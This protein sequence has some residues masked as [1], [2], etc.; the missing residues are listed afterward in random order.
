MNDASNVSTGKPK[1]TGSIFSAPLGT[2]LP[3]DAVS[4][5]AA[6]FVHHG[7]G[8]EDGVTNSNSPETEKIKAWGGD[9]VLVVQNGREDT[10]KVKLIEAMNLENL[11]V[12]YGQDNVTG[13]M[14]EGIAVS[15]NS[16][17]RENRSWVIDMV[18]KNAIKRIV[19]PDAGISELGEIKYADKEAIGYEIT[20]SAV[21]DANGNT[22]YEYIKKSGVADARLTG[23][24]IGSLELSPSFSASVTEYETETSNNSDAITATAASGATIVVLVNGSSITNGTAPTWRT[25]SNLV[26][27]TVD[28]TGKSA[29]K[30]VITVTKEE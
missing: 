3:T 25:G 14:E 10:F 12:V 6:A 22:H 7:Y 8:S 26:E 21:P 29:T 9:V 23:L 4:V 17:E 2:T 18:L 20:L 27:I 16:E 30:Y 13:T 1:I 24:S 19:I 15:A 11:K 5:L 28:E